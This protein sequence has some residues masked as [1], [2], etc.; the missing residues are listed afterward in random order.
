MLPTIL[1]SVL[2]HPPASRANEK[3]VALILPD[4]EA[5]TAK[6]VR[7]PGELCSPTVRAGILDQQ[8]CDTRSGRT[9]NNANHGGPSAPGGPSPWSHGPHGP[10]VLDCCAYSLSWRPT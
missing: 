1:A 2:D 10:H 5:S 8:P 7:G 4:D 9:G 6:A 3:Q